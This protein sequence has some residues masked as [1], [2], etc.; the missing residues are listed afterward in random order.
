MDVFE[1]KNTGPRKVRAD[2]YSPGI[3]GVTYD[4]M[5]MQTGLRVG[6]QW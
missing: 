2:N 4:E 5:I 6:L 1:L 3:L